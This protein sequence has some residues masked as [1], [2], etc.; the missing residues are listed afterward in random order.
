VNNLKKRVEKLFNR[1]ESHF[2]E[3]RTILDSVGY[4]LD[5]VSGSHHIFKDENG[6][7]I[8]FPVHNNLVKRCYVKEIIRKI[9]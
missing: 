3:I 5:R 8:V 4:Q 2:S 1:K 6:G 7:M 9:N